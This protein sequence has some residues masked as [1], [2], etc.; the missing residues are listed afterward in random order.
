MNSGKTNPFFAALLLFGALLPAGAGAVPAKPQL[1][2]DLG[3]AEI[4][5]SDYPAELQK[6]YREVLVPFFSKF[7]GTARVINSPLVTSDEWKK[8]IERI[9]TRPP[10]C[11][12]CPYLNLEDARALRKFLV[13]DSGRRKTGRNAAAWT[14]L[15]AGLV[16]RFNSQKGGSGR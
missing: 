16:E 8:E 2:E 10:C 13:Y 12:A 6:T 15:R 5:V 4:D 9:R 1:P 7:G 3:P 11:G 14:A